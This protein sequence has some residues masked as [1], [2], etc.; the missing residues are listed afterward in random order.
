MTT[1]SNETRVV[2]ALGGNALG[3]TPEEQIRRVREAAPELL[4]LIMQGN[5]I[6]ITHGNGPQVGMIQKA[7]TYAHQTDE[8]IPTVDLP[9]CGAMSQGYI[10]YH[11]QQ[12]IGVAMHKAYKRWH[13]ASVVTQTEVDPDDP[14][15]QNP[16][17]PIGAFLT[18]EQAEEEMAKHP[19]MQ[20]VEDSGRGWRRVVASPEPKKIVEAPSIL[21]LL[22]NEFIV[23]CT[24]GG[25]VPVVR[26]Y[27][28]KGCYKGVAAVIDK[29][30]GGELLA[31]DCKADV[32]I[33]L[34]AVD[35][36]AINFGTPEQEDLTDL[37]VE[38]AEKYVAEG[39]FG[40][41]SMEPKVKAGIKFAKS[42]AGRVCIIGSLEKAGAA[43]AGL[44][45]TRIHA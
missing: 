17:K 31:E 37:P 5:E 36:V 43:M 22:D 9:E 7:F 26:D 4:N 20:F 18:K 6:I 42:R 25:G 12:A 41:G 29:D 23:I 19:E 10:G 44:S 15:F 11:L 35:H 38:L 30:L 28:D 8:K 27:S 3:D 2:V 21:N 45:G 34:T 40:K 39:Q 16:T 1:T 33:L 32:L 14:A 13:V 24:G